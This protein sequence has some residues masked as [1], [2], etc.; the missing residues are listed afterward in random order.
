MKVREGDQKTKE[1]P[2]TQAFLTEKRL[3]YF[4][5]PKDE[6]SI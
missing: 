6:T 4:I 1:V 3:S 5:D 2:I